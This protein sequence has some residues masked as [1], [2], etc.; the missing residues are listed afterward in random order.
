MRTFRA[1]SAALLLFTSFFFSSQLRAAYPATSMVITVPVV[2]LMS[3]PVKRHDTYNRSMIQ[4]TQL[5]YGE[6]VQGFETINGWRRVKAIEQPAQWQGKWITCS[7]WIPHTFCKEVKKY[8]TRDLVVT[9]RSA[10]VMRSKKNE[11]KVTHLSFGTQLTS[12]GK[13]DGWWLLKLPEGGTGRIRETEVAYLHD[14]HPQ[15]HKR[16]LVAERARMFLGDPYLWAGRSAYNPE[17]QT[18][19]GADCSG[20]VNILYRSIGMTL[21]RCS[22]DQYARS[23]KIKRLTST[24]IGDL[25]FLYGQS[26][27]GGYSDRITHVMVYLGNDRFLEARGEDVS[28]VRIVLGRQYFGKALEEITSGEAVPMFKTLGESP[29]GHRKVT[30]ETPHGTCKLVFGSYLAGD[31]GMARD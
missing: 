31:S 26:D 21:P 19:T 28:H 13:K 24:N 6:H 16:L 1:V 15:E 25:M 5:L 2:H 18:L 30:N 20:L 11:E 27:S 3:K 4:A 17:A 12:I 22:H 23:T 9:A 14:E 8:P 29:M 7:G 10:T